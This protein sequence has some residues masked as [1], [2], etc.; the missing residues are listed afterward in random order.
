MQKRK[1]SKKSGPA[2][3]RELGMKSVTVFFGA[4]THTE[5]KKLS[6]SLRVPVATLVRRAMVYMIRGGD[7]YCR[8]LQ[9]SRYD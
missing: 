1:N 5:L 7:N 6:E 8:P 3:M 4:S 2:R 9:E